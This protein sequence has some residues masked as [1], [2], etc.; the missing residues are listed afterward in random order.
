MQDNDRLQGILFDA[1]DTIRFADA[2]SLSKRMLLKTRRVAHRVNKIKQHYHMPISG[3]IWRPKTTNQ[4][5][6]SQ[7]QEVARRL[8]IQ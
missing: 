6:K 4:L 8:K 2:S 5:R 7:T 1:D 3:G